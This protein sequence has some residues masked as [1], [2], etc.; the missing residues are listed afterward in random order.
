LPP[1]SS[2]SGSPD[3]SHFRVPSLADG[4]RAV[5]SRC[6][7]S[8]VYWRQGQSIGPD[9]YCLYIEG[10]IVRS[11]AARQ[12]LGRRV[13]GKCEKCGQGLPLTA[14]ALFP[15]C[16]RTTKSC[17]ACA[18]VC[19]LELPFSLARIF[20]KRSATSPNSTASAALAGFARLTGSFGCTQV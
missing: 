7:A 14:S 10:Q 11:D 6:L 8:P 13:A 9:T 15:Y 1:G 5:V 17:F 12:G 4:R 3:F 20:H 16:S 2:Y 18:P 19:A